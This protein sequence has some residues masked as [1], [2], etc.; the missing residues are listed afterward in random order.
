MRRR[1][2]PMKTAPHKDTDERGPTASV[3]GCVEGYLA[4]MLIVLAF[5]APS[6]DHPGNPIGHAVYIGIAFGLALGG[7]RFGKGGGRLAAQVALS[8][9]SLWL[10]AVLA[11]SIVRWEQVLWYWRH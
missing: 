4:L 7:V 1:K 11:V 9:L 5:L 6:V 2:R 3:A 10:L 8:V